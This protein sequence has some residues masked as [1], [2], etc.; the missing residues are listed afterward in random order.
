[1]FMYN[2]LLNAIYIGPYGGVSGTRSDQ[3]W[4]FAFV[5]ISL[6]G[7]RICVQSAY[8]LKAQPSLVIMVPSISM[9]SVFFEILGPL[10]GYLSEKR[11]RFLHFLSKIGTCVVR[12][13]ILAQLQQA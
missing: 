7:K 4:C 8:C 12:C 6:A 9:N 10:S 13:S 11:Q 3:K 1:M 2:L 5:F